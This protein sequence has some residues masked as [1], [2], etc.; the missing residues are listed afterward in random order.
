MPDGLPG[1]RWQD[2]SPPASRRHPSPCWPTEGSRAVYS[3]TRRPRAVHT[4]TR[5]S[6][7]LQ[8]TTSAPSSLT[9]PRFMLNQP[10]F[11]QPYPTLHNDGLAQL[12]Q[13]VADTG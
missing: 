13:P 3:Q 10:V 8:L 4:Q 1:L 9:I 7:L 2:R 12:L 11:Y 5:L 6:T